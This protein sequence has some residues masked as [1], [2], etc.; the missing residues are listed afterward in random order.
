M[1]RDEQYQIRWNISRNDRVS[2][3]E[4]IQVESYD[5]E[6]NTKYFARSVTEKEIMLAVIRE[7]YDTADEIALAMKR[8]D[9]AIKLQEH[10]DYVLFARTTAEL[11]LNNN[12]EI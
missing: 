4:N 9:D 7:R 2:I 11:I 3:P 10:E 5:F 8:E 1:L 6:Y 12:E